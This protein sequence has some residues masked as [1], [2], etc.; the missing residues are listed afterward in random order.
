MKD[1]RTPKQTDEMEVG[2]R[3]YVDDSFQIV[4]EV[5]TG[6]QANADAGFF[7]KII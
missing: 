3:L 4:H 7:V 1:S 5:E 2:I 6:V